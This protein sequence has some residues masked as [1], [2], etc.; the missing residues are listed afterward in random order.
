L[1]VEW[2][3]GLRVAHGRLRTGDERGTEV[4]AASFLRERRIVLDEALRRDPAEMGRILIHELFHFAWIRLSNATRASWRELLAR[5]LTRHARGEL[6]WSAESRKGAVQAAWPRPA[7]RAWRDYSCE[8]F[9][10]T[11]AWIHASAGEHDEY[12]LARRC[13]EIRRAWFQTMESHRAG[14]LRI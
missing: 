5:E 9:C 7:V 6:G 1:R 12:T 2:A 13:R 14:A 10:D 8:S 11:A 4:H 3:P